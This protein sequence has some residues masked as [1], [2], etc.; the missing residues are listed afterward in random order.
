MTNKLGVDMTNVTKVCFECKIEKSSENFYKDKAGSKGLGP[1][2]KNC[3]Y[4]RSKKWR[5][6][7][8]ERYYNHSKSWRAAHPEQKKITDALWRE[9]NK[10]KI[11]KSQSKYA[12]ANPEKIQEK[13]HRRRYKKITNGEYVVLNKFIKKLYAS[14]CVACGSKS[15]IHMDHVIPISR[16]GRHSEGNLQPLCAKCNLSKNNKTMMEWKKGK[17]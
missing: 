16:G 8:K 14:C 4:L 13:Y 6:N 5:E 9:K 11:K 17:K 15:N 12:K 3:S 7:N 10:D 1:Y 2:C